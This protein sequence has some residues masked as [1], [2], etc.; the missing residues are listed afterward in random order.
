MDRLGEKQ[1][2]VQ[3]QLGVEMVM[4]LITTDGFA[5]ASICRGNESDPGKDRSQ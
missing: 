4:Q 3:A 1:P 2:T 5:H